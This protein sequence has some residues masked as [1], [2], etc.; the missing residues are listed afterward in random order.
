MKKTALITGASSG[1]GLELARLFAKDNYDL[2]LIAR[3]KQKL[4][5]L[6]HE[7]EKHNL[8]VY[9]FSADLTELD[10]PQKI[11]DYTQSNNIHIDVLVNNAG[12]GVYGYFSSTS[13]EKELNMVQLNVTA[14][15]NLTK[16]FMPHMIRQKSGGILNVASTA[17]FQP[18]PKMAVYFASKAYVLSFSEALHNELKPHG[19]SVTCLCPGPTK[20]EFESRAATEEKMS[21]FN[22]SIMDAKTVA[23]IGYDGLQKQKAVVVTG[24]KNKLLIFIGRFAPRSFIR[25]VTGKLME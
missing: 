21:L 6:K 20:T 4:E 18:G 12:F 11:H 15:T 9:V 10:A 22:G 17:A 8:K 23:Q 3:R 13:R 16:L 2:V 19:I 7:L 5:E 14:L 24:L 1:I 25:F